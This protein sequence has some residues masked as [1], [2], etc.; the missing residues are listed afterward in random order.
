MVAAV[1]DLDDLMAHD[2]DSIDLFAKDQARGYG[3]RHVTTWAG[4]LSIRTA[5][6]L[7]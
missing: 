5:S 4:L 3:E 1:E 2:K 7:I 6:A